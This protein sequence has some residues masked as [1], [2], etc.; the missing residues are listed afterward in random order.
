MHH[1]HLN[2]VPPFDL[3]NPTS[4]N[5]ARSIYRL[6]HAAMQGEMVRLHSV[7]VSE[8]EASKATYMEL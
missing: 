3:E 1:K 8:K 2:E 4:E 5:L 7:S 6:L